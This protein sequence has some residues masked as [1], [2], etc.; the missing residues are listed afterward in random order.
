[1]KVLKEYKT[2]KLFNMFIST[3]KVKCMATSKISIKCKL[4]EGNTI[5]QEIKFKYLKMEN[6]GYG[7][8]EAVVR[9]HTIGTRTAAA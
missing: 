8:V 4:T 1:M 6:S 7:Q 2:I 3:A 5:Q 9:N